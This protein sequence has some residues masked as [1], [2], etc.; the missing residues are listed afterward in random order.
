[1]ES[2]RKSGVFDVIFEILQSRR[3][4][5]LSANF[6][7]VASL[8][9]AG[10]FLGAVSL[11]GQNELG[12]ATIP[13]T[14]GMRTNAQALTA[15]NFVAGG[16]SV[17]NGVL[18]APNSVPPTSILGTNITVRPVTLEEAVQ[19][20]L[21]NNYDIQIIRYNVDIA[22]FNLQGSYGAWE[23]AFNG[24]ADYSYDKS[25][26]RIQ[27][28]NG[29]LLQS[30]SREV[31]T[32][33]YTAGIDGFAPT[34][35]QYGLDSS[36]SHTPVTG[37]LDVGSTWT[38]NLRQPILRNFWIDATRREILLN[39]KR[40]Q[41]SEWQLREQL[42]NT[43]AQVENAYYDLI[44]ARENIKVQRAALDSNNQLLREN[45]KRVE[46]GALAPLDEKQS[47]A[48]VAHA[49]ATLLQTEQIYALSLNN[50]KNLVTR[51]FAK[52]S[53]VV[54]D[55]AETLV[56]VP[57]SP[58]LAESW[59][60][61][62]SMRPELQQLKLNI[63]AQNIT[64]KYLKNQVWP[65]LDLRGSY[66]HSGVDEQF[67]QGVRNMIRDDNPHYTYGAVL[68]IPLGGNRNA[69]YGLKVARKSADQLLTEYQQLEQNVMVSI[70]NAIKL[71]AS[72][73]EQVEAARQAR[74]FAQ[75]ALAAEQ[76]KYENGKS[77][78]YDVLL[79]QRDLT[80]RRF[81]EVAAL[82][83]YNKALVGLSQSEGTTLVRFNMNIANP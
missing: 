39:K 59:K 32:D 28:L 42:I 2:F 24:S 3:S 74:L 61:G 62:L 26:G 70:D 38:L 45:K 41:I 64:I 7:R 1:M 81:D 17:T 52:W 76:K 31:E 68:S 47:E 33:R 80:S 50:L 49:V 36:V 69:R 60:R 35:L 65:Q 71:L 67:S 37:P 57:A 14:A 9:S 55:P 29:T 19:M 12:S 51:D 34:G 25:P 46:V 58:E 30:P 40:I 56:A 22:R 78:S 13:P 21:E 10:V 43:I 82:A 48:E 66:G 75:D 63:E 79:K 72:Q 15:T 77:T 44:R 83:D 6:A 16:V 8:G 53:Q 20:A 73:F 11:F 23:P 27:N 5:H 4:M 18:V 54:F